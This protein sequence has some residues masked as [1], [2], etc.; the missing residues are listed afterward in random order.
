MKPKNIHRQQLWLW[1]TDWMWGPLLLEVT[2]KARKGKRIYFRLE[3]NQPFP[4]YLTR[5]SFLENC[6]Y[7]GELDEG[8]YE[9]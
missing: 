7:I 8:Q 2:C 5:Q 1:L 4:L 3:E 9:V 6:V